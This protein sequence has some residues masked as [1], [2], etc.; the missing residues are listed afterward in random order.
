MANSKFTIFTSSDIGG[1]GPIN[2]LTGS[3]ISMLDACLVTG[4]G[5]KYVGWTKPLG[6]ISGSLSAYLPASGSKMTL[7]VNDAGGNVTA[8][9][10]E[11]W[12]VGWES[13]TALTSSNT[14]FFTGSVGSGYGQFPTPLQIPLSSPTPLIT[15]AGGHLIWRKSSTADTNGRYWIMFADAY[16]AHLFI[17]TGDTAGYYYGSSFGNIYSLNGNNDAYRCLL[18]GRQTENNSVGNTA[19]LNIFTDTMDIVF[20]GGGAMTAPM[21]NSLQAHSG[22]YMARGW[23]GM[24]SSINVGKS[25][26]TSKLSFTSVT[27]TGIYNYWLY[28]GLLQ[29]PNPT[30]NTF[31]V[32]PISIIEPSTACIRGRW[33]GM[34]HLCHPAANFSDGQIINAAGDYAGKTFQIVKFAGL[35][36]GFFAVEISNTV[37]TN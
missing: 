12:T 32:S 19:A 14:A 28:S 37:E 36:G 6:T 26:D 34:Y 15:S 30:D 3:L 23:S 24:G 22:H 9:G 18:I 27:I 11:A 31:Y 33:R 2:G 25:G 35:W 1:P 8:G 20:A 16:T 17:N 29:T 13:M 7:F 5:E 21:V 10:K 4:Y